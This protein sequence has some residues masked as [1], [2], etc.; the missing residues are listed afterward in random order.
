MGFY[1]PDEERLEPDALAALQ[2]ARL[3]MLLAEVA[4]SNDFY[5]RKLAPWAA[6]PAQTPLSELPLTTR[7]EVQR[8][9]TAHPPYGTNLT[10]ARG[11]YTRV[12]QSSG[13]TGDPM[14]WLDTPDS[15]AW[16]KRCW[17]IVFR[18]A[19]LEASDRVAFPFSFGPFLG[20]WVALESAQDL[21][22]FVVAAGGMT[23]PARLRLI[24]ENRITVVC[25]TP[26]YALHMAEVAAGDGLDLGRS[27]VRMLVV[28]GEPGGN[29]S[30]VRRRIESTWGARVIDHAG[31]TEIGPWG[32]ECAEVEGGMHVIESEFIA[33][34]LDPTSGRPLP[35]GERGELVLT[36]LGRLGSPLIRY[37]TGDQVVLSRGRCSCGRWYARVE[38]GVEGRTDDMLLIRGNNV[39]PSAI[40]G[41]VR[42]FTEVAEFRLRVSER[43]SMAE[44]TIEIEPVAGVAA[45]ASAGLARRIAEAVRDRLHFR[46]RVE[47]VLPGTLPRFE[48]KARRVVS[49]GG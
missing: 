35:D 19:G 47:T 13:T 39:F 17:S 28:A 26:T 27:A 18:G 1:L 23:T 24:L 37:R 12:H 16:C 48:M 46:P 21:G 11:L 3:G 34:V 9:Q 7:E 32:F 10:Y 14:R 40:E 44:L 5:R 41:I 2:R 43:S 45:E 6:D 31:M 20:F 38:A 22:N 49:G 30:S 33:E 42:R 8:D 25:C 36:N 29:I 4:R 15:W